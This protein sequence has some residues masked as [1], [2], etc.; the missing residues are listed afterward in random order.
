VRFVEQC[1]DV[2]QKRVADMHCCAGS[3]R[4][5]GPA[6]G[7]LRDGGENVVVAVE[8]E[9][10]GKLHPARA[11]FGVCV[12]IEPTEFEVS[13]QISMAKEVQNAHQVS[14]PNMGMPKS[15]KDSAWGIEK[16]M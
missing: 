13:T 15:E 4:N 6:V 7:L 16:Y 2:G 10:G 8:G 5:R 1:I 12:A 14:T 11:Q 3:G 9:E